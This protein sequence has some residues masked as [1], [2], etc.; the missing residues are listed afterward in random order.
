MRI[1][2]RIETKELN[3]IAF[4]SKNENQERKGVKAGQNLIELKGLN[5]NFLC[6]FA[7]LTRASE[8]I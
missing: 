8:Q 7:H 5:N 6:D 4:Q 1:F 3:F 2:F